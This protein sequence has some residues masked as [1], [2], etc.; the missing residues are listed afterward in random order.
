MRFRPAREGRVF[1]TMHRG[2]GR[3]DLREARGWVPVALA[4]TIVRLQA[5]SLGP[6]RS[7]R[8]PQR[9]PKRGVARPRTQGSTGRPG[10]I[11]HLGR[12]VLICL[13]VNPGGLP[14][15]PVQ[16]AWDST[17]R[18]W[19]RRWGRSLVLPRLPGPKALPYPFSGW[20]D[21]HSSHVNFSSYPGPS[22]WLVGGPHDPPVD[23]RNCQVALCVSLTV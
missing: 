10:I 18:P 6:P 19:S 13:R 21:G 3:G 2:L 14:A 7:G 5:P 23:T 15:L 4:L 9:H 22:L 8:P 11:K 12:D 16:P 1:P 17:L 20:R